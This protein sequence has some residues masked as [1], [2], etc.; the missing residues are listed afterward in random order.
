MLRRCTGFD[1]WCVVRYIYCCTV[2]FCV[3]GEAAGVGRAWRNPSVFHQ[4]QGKGR[5]DGRFF[6]W[7]RGTRVC[8]LGGAIPRGRVRPAARFSDRGC[9]VKVKVLD[10]IES[11]VLFRC[12]VGGQFC[13]GGRGEGS[14]VVRQ[15]L[16]ALMIGV[17]SE[18]GLSFSPLV[19]G[20]LL[21]PLCVR[22]FFFS[23][24]G[25]SR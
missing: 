24:L 18:I 1:S 2:F 20:T 6:S 3:T 17:E 7:E 11:G 8:S 12:K 16:L 4:R 25:G 23:C 10:S 21:L 5:V 22:F 14:I 15:R 13:V 19:C 9:G